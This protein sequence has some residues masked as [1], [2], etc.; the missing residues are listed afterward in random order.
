MKWFE[1]AFVVY[2]AGYAAA[3]WLCRMAATDES[4]NPWPWSEMPRE[5]IAFLALWPLAM[6]AFAVATVASWFGVWE[7]RRA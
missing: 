3:I 6:V 4:G 2:G 7:A 1:L 5:V